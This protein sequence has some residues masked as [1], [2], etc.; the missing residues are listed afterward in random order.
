[1]G[2]DLHYRMEVR[3]LSYEHSYLLSRMPTRCMPR[4]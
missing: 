1:M 3:E 4:R 2:R